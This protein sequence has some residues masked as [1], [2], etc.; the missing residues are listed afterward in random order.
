MAI[1]A[2]RSQVLHGVSLPGRRGTRK[3]RKMMDM[4][5][6]T[7][8]SVTVRCREVKI[9]DVAPGSVVLYAFGARLRVPFVGIDRDSHSEPF[10]ELRPLRKLL[11]RQLNRLD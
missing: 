11:R 7:A 5:S 10:G 1:R 6:A 8:K 2:D 4:D 3:R 9:T